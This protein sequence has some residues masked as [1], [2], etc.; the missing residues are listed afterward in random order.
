VSHGEW[1]VLSTLALDGRG[2]D[3]GTMPS[4]LADVCGVSPSTMTHRLDRMAAKNL[5]ARRADP[6]NRTRSRVMLTDQG[7]EL[8]RRAVL[9]AEVVESSILSPLDPR[10]QRQLAALLEKVVAGLRPS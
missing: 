9:D 1:T 3:G 6:D 8:F 2:R 4:R 7:W 5:I 10:E